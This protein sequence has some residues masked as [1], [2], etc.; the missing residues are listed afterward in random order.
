MLKLVPSP[1]TERE[2]LAIVSDIALQPSFWT[3][4]IGV[5]SPN[6]FVPLNHIHG[7]GQDGPLRY[8]KVRVS[9]TRQG[10]G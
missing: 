2:Q 6:G 9:G 1:E 3:K 7:H 4:N 10:F 5:G 8:G